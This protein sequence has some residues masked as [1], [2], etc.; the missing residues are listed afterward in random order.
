MA[1]GVRPG[2]IVEVEPHHGLIW[3][4]WLAAGDVAF[5][6]NY[7]KNMPA[8]EITVDVQMEVFDQLRKANKE[9][10]QA[11]KAAMDAGLSERQVQMAERMAGI[12]S[13]FGKEL[14][15]QLDL[16]GAQR[17]HLPDAINRALV[18]LEAPLSPTMS[19]MPYQGT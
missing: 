6:Q 10:R 13:R 3:S 16:T 9:M 15:D 4:V 19:T 7:L 1:P 11:A 12:L 14:A 17:K 5:W 2:D 8:D 18:I